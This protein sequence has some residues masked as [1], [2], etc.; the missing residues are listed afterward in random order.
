MDTRQG[1]TITATV[2]RARQV[3]ETEWLTVELG[4]SRSVYN[5][6]PDADVRDGESLARQLDEAVQGLIAAQ[7][8]ERGL[9]SG[10]STDTGASPEHEPTMECPTHAGAGMRLRN[11][12]DGSHFYSHKDDSTGGVWCNY[13]PR[14]S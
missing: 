9:G 4:A 12:K 5:L 14:Y 11:R 13:Q 8:R 7:G 10:P 3:T 1:P 6:D 2:R